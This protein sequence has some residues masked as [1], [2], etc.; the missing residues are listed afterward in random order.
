LG[1]T[2]ILHWFTPETKAS[3]LAARIAKRKRDAGEGPY[4]APSEL[5]QDKW[6]LKEVLTIMG[7]PVSGKYCG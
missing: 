7:R 5:K 4:Y 1:F 2:Q 3:V 6:N